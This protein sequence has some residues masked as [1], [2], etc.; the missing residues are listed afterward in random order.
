MPSPARSSSGLPLLAL[1]VARVA[2]REWHRHHVV[3][4][5]AA[6]PYNYRDAV[7]REVGGRDRDVPRPWA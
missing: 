2:R 4:V 3:D 1:N 5:E 6:A 7:R